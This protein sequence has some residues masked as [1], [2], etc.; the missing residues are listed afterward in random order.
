MITK[1]TKDFESTTL[2]LALAQGET[3]T[4]T[5]KIGTGLSIPATHSYLQIDYNSTV[6]LGSADAPET[7]YYTGYNSVDGQLTGVAR[8]K[9]GTTDVAHSAGAEV[10]CAMSTA[11]LE[12]NTGWKPIK[13]VFSY[14][15]ATTINVDTGATTIYSVGDKL[16][17]KQT[18][19]TYVYFYVVTVAAALLTVKGN[20]LANE[21]ITVPD[22]SKSTSPVGF[23]QWFAYTPTGV[24]A[25][26]VTLTGR[27]S[28][29]GRTCITNIYGIFTGAITFTTMPTLPI[30]ASANIMGLGV[31]IATKGT[32]SYTDTGTT[33]NPNALSPT[34]LASGTVVNVIRSTDGVV[35]SATVPITWANNDAFQLYF[36]YEI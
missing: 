18:A 29:N 2:S 4:I 15:S 3:G 12:D 25:S 19:G 23:P 20:T 6:A 33:D 5:A 7:I 28:L 8:G 27:F 13:G 22:M 10:Q 17:F 21:A 36:T 34:V 16:R 24:S 26:N 35:M 31:E 11:F 1:P 30:A 9:Q 32:G 14:A